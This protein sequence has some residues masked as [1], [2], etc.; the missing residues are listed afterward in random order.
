MLPDGFRARLRALRVFS[1]PLSVIPVAVAA[2]AALPPSDWR[3]D[4]LLVS[5]LGVMTLHASGNLLNDYF[6]FRSGVDRKQ[7]A[8]DGRPGRLLV[9]GRLLPRDILAEAFV[10]LLIAAAAGAYLTWL[11]GPVVLAFGLTGVAGLYAYTGPPFHLK[12][13]A[14]GEPLIFLVFGPLL[15]LGAAYAQTRRLEPLALALSFPIGFA[16]TAVLVGNNLRDRAEDSDAGIVTLVHA[17]GAKGVQMLYLILLAGALAG[18]VLIALARWGPIALAASPVCALLLLRPVARTLQGE[19][20]PDIDAK[21]ARF[22]TA[23]MLFVLAALV[24][25]PR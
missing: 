22:A 25:T 21:T 2:A 1:F 7:E 13:R 17:L 23:L 11:R 24:L 10:A 3:W 6:D 16:T 12:Y 15:M 5:L 14:L 19:R 8:D 18:L 20:L 4:I 9:R